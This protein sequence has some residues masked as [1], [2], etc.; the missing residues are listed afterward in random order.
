MNLSRAPL[1]DRSPVKNAHECNNASYLPVLACEYARKL[2][3]E[4][5]MEKKKQKQNIFL[6]TKDQRKT[7]KSDF[8]PIII[9]GRAI[10][11]SVKTFR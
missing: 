11:H 1:Y 8:E 2:T 4:P 9:V 6:C 5:F 7:Y 10:F 3:L